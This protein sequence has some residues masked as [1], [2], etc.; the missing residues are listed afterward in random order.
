METAK[1]R[2]AVIK[3]L[4]ASRKAKL[5]FIL[6]SSLLLVVT[7]SLWPRAKHLPAAHAAGNQ[8]GGTPT[9]NR[10]LFVSGGAVP[11]SFG[12]FVTAGLGEHRVRLL[13]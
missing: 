4:G 13:H 11:A 10:L 9:T 7:L 8:I 2:F 6:A 12:D 5:G 3:R 1:A